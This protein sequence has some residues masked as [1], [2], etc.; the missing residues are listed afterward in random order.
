MPLFLLQICQ[1]FRR[2]TVNK[3]LNVVQFA[4]QFRSL[5]R[6]FQLAFSLAFIH[7]FQMRLQRKQF[8][9]RCR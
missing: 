9:G 2:D 8:A 6:V 5:H 1:H 3:P 4:F 7:I